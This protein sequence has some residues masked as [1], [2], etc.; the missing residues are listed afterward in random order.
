VVLRKH[1]LGTLMPQADH[2]PHHHLVG[3]GGTSRRN[4]F[5][6]LT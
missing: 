3:A 1:Q 6:V 4:A 2:P 5:A